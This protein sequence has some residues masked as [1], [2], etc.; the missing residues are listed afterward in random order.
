VKIENGEFKG[1]YDDGGTKPWVCCDGRH[2]DTW[3]EPVN[4]SFEGEPFSW[5]DVANQ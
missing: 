3:H 4:L 2:P 1:V 5:S